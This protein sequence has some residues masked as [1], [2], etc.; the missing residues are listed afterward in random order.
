MTFHT[1][2]DFSHLSKVY[3]IIGDQLA[4]LLMPLDYVFHFFLLAL[5]NYDIYHAFFSLK[6]PYRRVNV[7]AIAMRKKRLYQDLKHY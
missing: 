2:L 6:Y 3:R 4:V 7:V 1:I 5:K